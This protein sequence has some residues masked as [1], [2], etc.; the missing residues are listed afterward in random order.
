MAVEQIA[1]KIEDAVAGVKQFALRFAK[2]FLVLSFRPRALLRSLP[3]NISQAGLLHPNAFLVSCA[4]T[5]GFLGKIL[6]GGI[7]NIRVD[8]ILRAKDLTLSSFLSQSVPVFGIAIV[9]SGMVQIALWGQ[10]RASKRLITHLNYYVIGYFGL[11]SLV[12]LMLLAPILSGTFDYFGWRTRLFVSASSFVIGG[13]VL[14][15]FALLQWMC[16]QALRRGDEVRSAI[17]S[18]KLGLANIVVILLCVLNVFSPLYRSEG[19]DPL[20]G[21]LLDLELQSDGSSVRLTYLLENHADT[22]VAINQTDPHL[23]FVETAAGERVEAEGSFRKGCG[24]ESQE[25]SF[26]LLKPAEMSVVSSC[27]SSPAL[28]DLLKRVGFLESS[29]ESG[30]R[31]LMAPRLNAVTFRLKIEAVVDSRQRTS[32]QVSL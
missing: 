9:A 11:G 17:I 7:E 16:M 1:D 20:R 2:T 14:A 15:T 6:S 29:R 28:S 18:F 23:V 5:L 31:R 26:Q 3:E 4:I 25:H 30:A 32:L 13:Y 8:T 19:V 10:S 22:T 24:I 21:S 12:V 27:V